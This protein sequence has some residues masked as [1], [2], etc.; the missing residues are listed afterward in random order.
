MS[1]SDVL[2]QHVLDRYPDEAATLLGREDQQEI[3]TLLENETLARADAIFR[4]IGAQLAAQCLSLLSEERATKLL[5]ALDEARIVEIFALL[6]AESR[7]LYLDRLPAALAR[8]VREI[9]DYPLDSA[10]SL[11]DRR[12][13]AFGLQTTIGDA[14]LGTRKIL[15]RSSALRRT[16]PQYLTV[17]GDDRKLLGIVPLV[18]AAL[19]EPEEM[20]ER[21]M[22][23]ASFTVQATAPRQEVVEILTHSQM[24]ALPVVDLDGHLLGVIRHET[25]IQTVQ[26]E[27]MVGYQTMVGVSK[28]ERALSSPWLSV[29]RRLPWLNINLLTAFAA[30][31][32][33]GL[34]EATIAQVTALAVMLPVVAGQSGNTGAQALAVTM[35]GLAL[36]E[37]R[38][39]HGP[40]VLFKEA[41]VGALNGLAI[42]LVTAIGVYVWS[43]SVGLMLVVAIAMVL[44]MII[45][46]LAGAAIPLILT[47]LRQD[48]AQSGSIILTTITDIAGFFSF[49]GLATLM[50]DAL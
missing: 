16:A 12:V 6:D 37:I 24:A 50:I 13:P 36:R 42:A 2:V 27:A 33:V 18:D 7:T 17:V 49:L 46:G 28:D 8:E 3:A 4:R 29:K 34:F 31:A 14:L 19:A 22:K 20:L 43:Q 41:L 15:R 44:S 45:A 1:Y 32:V 10:G 26:S 25:L 39:R 48:P 35:R 30:A 5:T 38:L 23:P 11:M 47:L 9:T 21:Y 40:R